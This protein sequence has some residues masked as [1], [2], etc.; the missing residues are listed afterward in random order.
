M[1]REWTVLHLSHL[2][3]LSNFYPS[4]VCH[5]DSIPTSKLHSSQLKVLT[6]SGRDQGGKSSGFMEKK[7]V[8]FVLACKEAEETDRTGIHHNTEA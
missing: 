4:L 8:C 5:S 3:H 6:S 2:S 1:L 7:C